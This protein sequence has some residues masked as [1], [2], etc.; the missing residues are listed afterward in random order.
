MNNFFKCTAIFLL[1]FLIVS[2]QNKDKSEQVNE[3]YL[4]KNNYAV[5]WQWETTDK[6]YVLKYLTEQSQ[7]LNDLWKKEIVENVYLNVD[8]NL[9]TGDLFPDISFIIKAKDEQ[10]AKIYLDN[11][12]FVKNKISSYKLYRV[13]KK[14]LGRNNEILDIIGKKK[15]FAAVFETL[16]KKEQIMANL[17][18]QNDKTSELWKAGKIENAY[19]DIEGFS[20]RKSNIPGMVYFVNADDEEIA[21]SILNELPFVKKQLTK[22]QLFPVGVFYLGEYSNKKN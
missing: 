8:S 22:Y 3:T 9:P 16:G 10:T 21:N 1:T 6:E 5:V 17:Q 11:M 12:I 15:S 13:G 2:C 20:S 7:E 19:L 18:E 4:E 14:Y